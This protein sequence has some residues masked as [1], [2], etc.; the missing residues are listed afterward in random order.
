MKQVLE[1]GGLGGSTLNGH[2]RKKYQAFV[3]TS[4]YNKHSQTGNDGNHVG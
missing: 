4:L 1:T 2:G 3:Y